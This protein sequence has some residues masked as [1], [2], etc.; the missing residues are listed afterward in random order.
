MFFHALV[1]GPE[2]QLLLVHTAFFQRVHIATDAGIHKGRLHVDQ[3]YP[4]VLA[5]AYRL[6]QYI[7]GLVAVFLGEARLAAGGF[8]LFVDPAGLLFFQHFADYRLAVDPHGELGHGAALGNREAVVGFQIL[9][10]GIMEDLFHFSDG[11]AV[12]HIHGDML[13]ADL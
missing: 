9:I 1:G 7:K 4:G 11:I 5:G 12:F 6:H 2:C 3:P 10:I 13:F 8:F